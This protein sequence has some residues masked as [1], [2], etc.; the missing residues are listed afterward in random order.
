MAG[1]GREQVHPVAWQSPCGLLS[2]D[3]PHSISRG[4]C[5]PGCGLGGEASLS[6]LCLPLHCFCEGFGCYPHGVSRPREGTASG[7]GVV[8]G[9]GDLGSVSG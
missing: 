5:L 1:G 7:K 8:P 3:G 9:S 2:R 6:P 4:P